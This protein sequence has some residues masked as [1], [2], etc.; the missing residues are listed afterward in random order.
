MAVNRNSLAGVAS[1]FA[2]PATTEDEWAKRI[3]EGDYR[4]FEDLFRTYYV[5][6]LRFARMFTRA[7]ETAEEVVQETMASIWEHRDKW[8]PHGSMRAYLYGAVKRQAGQLHRRQQVRNRWFCREE[9][10]DQRHACRGIGPEDSLHLK[11]LQVKIE[12]AISELP[13]RRRIIFLLSRNQGLTYAEIGALL[14]ISVKTVDTQIG[15][16]IK[17]LRRQV[18]QLVDEINT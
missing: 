7:D 9:L 15:R 5:E 2:H 17:Y 14:N 13:E 8:R 12:K 16:S 10:H 4:S 3:R 11:N 1:R 6:L 18:G